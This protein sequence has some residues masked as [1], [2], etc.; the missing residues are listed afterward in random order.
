M[1]RGDPEYNVIPAPFASEARG[2]TRRAP[3]HLNTR[4]WVRRA[5]VRCSR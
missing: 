2:R 3:M 4:V 5:A 1:P